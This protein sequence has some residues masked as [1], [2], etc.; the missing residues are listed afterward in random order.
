[1]R[2][3]PIDLL[4]PPDLPPREPPPPTILPVLARECQPAGTG[5]AVDDMLVGIAAFDHS[6]RIRDRVLIEALGWKPGDPTAVWLG[7]DVAVIRR[8]AEGPYCVDRRGQVFV[9]AATR[10]M[11]GI[12]PRER[13]VLVAL[14]RLG[15][16]LVHPP[17]VL[18]DLLVGHYGRN[19]EL[20]DER[21]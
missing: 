8:L 12:G 15:R 14:P 10:S 1:M 18:A 17:A 20:F 13:A 16:L 2:E 21:P 19:V 9:P 7:S 6:G 5:P 3:R 11:L 4:I